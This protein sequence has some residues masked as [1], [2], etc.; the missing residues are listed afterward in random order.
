MAPVIKPSDYSWIQK[1]LTGPALGGVEAGQLV[2]GV[3]DHTWTTFTD[4]NTGHTYH[5]CLICLKQEI[6]KFQ[7]LEMPSIPK[8][9]IEH[10]NKLEAKDQQLSGCNNCDHV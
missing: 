5:K 8:E 3:C 4:P 10:Q 9:F 6:S 1:K 7:L 2:L